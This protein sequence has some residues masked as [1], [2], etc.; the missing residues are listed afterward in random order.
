MPPR[1]RGVNLLGER[2]KAD[3]PLCQRGE[4]LNQHLQIA[5]KAVEPPDY[6]Y[7]TGAEKV[8]GFGETGPFALATGDGVGEDTLTVGGGEGILLQGEGLLEGGNTRI[9]NIHALIVAQA[10]KQYKIQDEEY[11]TSNERK[12]VGKSTVNPV[13]A[14]LLIAPPSY[15]S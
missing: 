10:V 1:G 13:M 3:S 7:I 4:G 9:T 5:T 8:E 12:G 15:V 6:E 11:K 2:A 14:R